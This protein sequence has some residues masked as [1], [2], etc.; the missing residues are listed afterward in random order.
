ME[1]RFFIFFLVLSLALTSFSQ[2][3]DNINVS[4][5]AGTYFA[6]QN[7]YNR[8]GWYGMYMEYMPIK[9]YSGLNLG[10]CAVASQSSFNS[11]DSLNQYKGT[12]T[13]F[14]V[15]LAAGQYVEF[16][17]STFSGYFGASL[18]FKRSQDLGEGTSIIK[19]QNSVGRYSMQQ[20]SNILEG[21]LNINLLKSFGFRE[22]LFPRTQ[23]R[24]LWQKP[25]NGERQSFWNNVPI[26][27][28]DLWNK[29]SS[30][31]ELKQSLFQAGSF[32]LLFEPKLWVG[33][34]HYVGDKSDWIAFGPEFALKMRG[35]DDFITLY[36]LVKKQ[37]GQFEPN[38]NSTQFIFGINFM[39]FNIQRNY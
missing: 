36:F 2:F 25:L 1:K 13:D 29:A 3:R 10:F 7:T 22:N 26:K 32:D 33:Y 30:G 28:S 5:F 19:P 38:L 15:G 37:V 16:L 14:G 11:Q 39:P 31:V 12:T 6:Q 18:M 21:S 34:Y 35:W 27:E 4:L 20:K 23:L 17:T 8:G 24:C 9:T